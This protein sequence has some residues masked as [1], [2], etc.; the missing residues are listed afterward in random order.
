D[1]QCPIDRQS[2]GLDPCH[3]GDDD[4]AGVSADVLEEGRPAEERADE[5]RAGRHRLGS[6]LADPA[7][8]QARNNRGQER[9]ENDKEYSLHQPRIRLEASTAIEPRRR[10][11]MTRMAR[12]IAASAAATVRTNIASTWPVR[13]PRYAEKA[14]RLMFTASRISSIAISIRMTFRRLRK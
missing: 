11:K 6:S 4:R 9:Q 10:K 13:S 2:A 5:Q 12:P 14:T 8:E 1:A 3:D 7:A